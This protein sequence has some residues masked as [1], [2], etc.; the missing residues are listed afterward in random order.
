M[1]L[2]YFRIVFS[3]P[4]LV[5]Y[6]AP[7]AEPLYLS[8]RCKGLPAQD[9]LSPTRFHLFCRGARRVVAAE[10]AERE[11]LRMPFVTKILLRPLPMPIKRSLVYL[12]LS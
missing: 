1:L 7:A 2:H 5:L 8:S 11:H 12:M 6:V 10:L 9:P 3:F 4:T